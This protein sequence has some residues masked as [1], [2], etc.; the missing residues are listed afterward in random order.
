MNCVAKVR[1]IR[2]SRLLSLIISPCS[3]PNQRRFLRSGGRGVVEDILGNE[4]K[5]YYYISVIVPYR[6]RSIAKNQDAIMVAAYAA[7]HELRQEQKAREKEKEGCGDDD[8]EGKGSSV[9]RLSAQEEVNAATRLLFQRTAGHTQSSEAV[10]ADSN[11]ARFY[12]PGAVPDSET[13]SEPY[14]RIETYHDLLE[15]E[16][17]QNGW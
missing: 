17:A 6:L 13:I 16:K 4:A 5:E 12:P 10:V 7:E 3:E 9:R 8:D 2:V 15:A 1:A 11:D 14:I